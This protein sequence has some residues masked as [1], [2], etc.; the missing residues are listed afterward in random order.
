MLALLRRRDFGL[1]WFGGFVSVAGDWVLDVALPFFVYDRTGSTVATAGMI[2]AELV[3]GVVLGSVGGVFADRW[4]RKR[5]LVLGNLLAAATVALL[6]SV[7][8]GGWLG[9]VYVVAVA[10]AA[11]AAFMT[12][13]ESALLPT[14]V[15]GGDLVAANALNALNNRLGRLVGVPLGGALLGFLGLRSVVLVDCATFVAAALLIAPIVVPRVAAPQAGE[16]TVEAARSAWATFA[17]EWVGGMR[18]VRNERTIAVIFVV[19]GLMTFGGTML[20]PLYVAWVRD[21]LGRGPAV[22]SWLLT[23]HSV[24]GIVGTVFVGRFAARLT[25]RALMG[26]TSLYAGVA[27]AVKFGLTSVA[28]AIGVETLAQ[29]GVKDEYRGRVFGALGASG[30]LLSLLGAAVGGVLGGIVGIVPALEVACALLV[31]SG[32]VVLRALEGHPAAARTAGQPDHV[33]RDA[34]AG[35]T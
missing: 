34:A 32:V 26:W 3:P 14:L 20:D 16:S 24:A 7:P 6:L 18:I 35:E 27:N 5:V 10:Q 33:E 1:L 12:P 8:G 15:V 9:L 31:L 2:V 13:A 29:R 11:I 21:V 28:S 22:Y 25:P 4:N 30:S 17:H 23:A 19:F